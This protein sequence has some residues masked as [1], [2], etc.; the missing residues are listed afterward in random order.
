VDFGLWARTE[1]DAMRE[2]A[3]RLGVGVELHYLDAPAEE[4]WRRIEARN[5]Q[6][7]W[8]SH[9]ISREDFDEWLARFEAPGAAEL[10]LF[11]LPLG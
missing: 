4:L 10:A 7:P 2:T 1:R 6:P 5:K 3:R 11:D 9:P 8:D